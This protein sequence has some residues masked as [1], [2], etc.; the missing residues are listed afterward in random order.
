M[1]KKKNKK[2]K[3]P[4]VSINATEDAICPHCGAEDIYCYEHTLLISSDEVEPEDDH[5]TV[6]C[7]DCSMSYNLIIIQR[8]AFITGI[9]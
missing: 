3:E 5:E 2:P 1:G 8:P 7:Q 4:I 9:E 6:F